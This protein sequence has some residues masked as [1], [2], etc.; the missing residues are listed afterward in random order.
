[1]LQVYNEWM[2]DLGK[3]PVSDA[4]V[5]THLKQMKGSKDVFKVRARIDGSKMKLSTVGNPDGGKSDMLRAWHGV[6]WKSKMDDEN[7]F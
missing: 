1:M 2:E 7:P 6:K 4:Y 3:K 5:G